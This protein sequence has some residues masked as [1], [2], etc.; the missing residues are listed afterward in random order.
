MSKCVKTFFLS[1]ET[2]AAAF[3]LALPL[4]A[5]RD[6][7]RVACIP[8]GKLALHLVQLGGLALLRHCVAPLDTPAQLV[9]Q[10]AP[11]ARVAVGVA[12][13]AC[14]PLHRQRPELADFHLGVR[15]CPLAVLLD[16][17]S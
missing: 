6:L 12:R 13:K 1:T 9:R 5:A 2:I 11:G 15:L 4:S 8:V 7:L 3:L 17:K 14:L 16:R 10:L